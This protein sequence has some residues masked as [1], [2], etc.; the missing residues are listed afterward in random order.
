MPLRPD[1]WDGCAA[2]VLAGGASR[3]LGR[4]K[5][6]EPLPTSPTVLDAVLAGVPRATTVVVVGPVRATAR[7]VITTREDPPGSGPA[8]GV[9]AGFRAVRRWVDPAPP[10]VVVLAGD[11]PFAPAAVPALLAA[12][13]RDPVA[14]VAVAE[15]PDGHTQPLL[16]VYRTPALGRAVDTDLSSRPARALMDHLAVVRVPVAE[17]TLLD[18][19][20]PADLARARRTARARLRS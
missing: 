17:E 19:D 7:P 4:D 2:V 3:R 5:L 1:P 15:G 13:R 16:A 8:A 14:D 10:H 18:V 9:A 6:V 12:L 11:A 20:T